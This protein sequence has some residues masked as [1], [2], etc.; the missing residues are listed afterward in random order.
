MHAALRALPEKFQG[1]PVRLAGESADPAY[2]IQV[3]TAEDYF[4]GWTG[5]DP[6]AGMGLAHWL[7]TPTQTFACLTAGAVF[8][9][10]ARRLAVRR[11]ALAWYPDDVW[12]Y[13][14]LDRL[15]E[16]GASGVGAL[17]GTVDQAA[18]NT[19]LLTHLDRCRAMGPA[20]GLPPR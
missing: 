11:D 13:A 1:Y 8:H 3:T 9:D 7:L 6:A 18:D 10:P 2:R 14:L 12:R 4:T 16:R 5:V 15:G 17:P 19:D 20:L